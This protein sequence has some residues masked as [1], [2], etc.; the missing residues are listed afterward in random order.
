MAGFSFDV[1][2]FSRLSAHM[3]KI[4]ADVVKKER[5]LPKLAANEY[6]NDVQAI[7]PYKR[8]DLRRSVHV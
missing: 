6:K 4:A 5:I 1:S 2:D 7:I 3:S 8:G